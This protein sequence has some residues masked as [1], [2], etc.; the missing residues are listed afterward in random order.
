MWRVAVVF[1]RW[2]VTRLTEGSEETTWGRVSRPARSN[3]SRNQSAVRQ[4]EPMRESP[5]R[6]A[7]ERPARKES[8]SPFRRAHVSMGDEAISTGITRRLMPDPLNPGRD[9]GRATTSL[10]M[11]D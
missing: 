2:S 3:V 4:A 6:A 1:C 9:R 7:V 5:P 10:G 11:P 8:P